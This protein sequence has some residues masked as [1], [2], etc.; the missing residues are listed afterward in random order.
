MRVIRV[1]N[2]TV[3][4][5]IQSNETPFIQGNINFGLGAHIDINY[6]RCS[7]GESVSIWE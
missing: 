1:K 2:K 3:V 7:N 4:L 6:G 5:K